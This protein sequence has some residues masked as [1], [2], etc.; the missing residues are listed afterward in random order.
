MGQ[1]NAPRVR[2]RDHRMSDFFQVVEIKDRQL[3]VN[4]A[5][6]KLAGCTHLHTSALQA[7]LAGRLRV[8]GDKTFAMQVLMLVATRIGG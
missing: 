4:G 3:Y 1:V 6:V 5:R 8:D 2:D 7:L